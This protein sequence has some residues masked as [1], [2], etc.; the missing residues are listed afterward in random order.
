MLSD[1]ITTSRAVKDKVECVKSRVVGWGRSIPQALLAWLKGLTRRTVAFL[2]SVLLPV[3]LIIG[4]FALNPLLGIITFWT[5]FII[6][7]A[8]GTASFR[9][10]GTTER[11]YNAVVTSFHRPV[12][13]VGTGWQRV[14]PYQ[15]I[16]KFPTQQYQ[17]PVEV[18][19]I[20]KPDPDK[21]MSRRTLDVDAIVYFRW[22]KPGERDP[23]GNELLL[24]AFYA[25]PVEDLTKP[26]I[27]VLQT[28]LRGS[29][30]SAFRHV[31]GGRSYEECLEDREL[32]EKEVK[33]NLLSQSGD[34]FVELGI[35]R[36]GMDIR[37]AE[38]RIGDDLKE[39]LSAGE[40]AQRHAD[41]EAIEGKGRG[42]RLAAEGRGRAK[43]A[44][45]HVAALKQHGIESGVAAVLVE[46]PDILGALRK[47]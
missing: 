22:A 8:L 19:V 21:G 31:M 28:H 6:G 39:A 29:V 43:A 12:R 23:S 1:L 11:P 47:P 32:V 7:T 27:E 33:D 41:A 9:Q 38:I 3:G 42:R 20:T 44:Q 15:G 26:H 13:V 17:I 25:V 4:M 24:K 2:L 36:D 46:A 14:R 16:R 5:V 34:P 40:N 10:V 45:V 35:P 37:V 30:E 18:K